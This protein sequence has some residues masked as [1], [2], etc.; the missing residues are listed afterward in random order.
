MKYSLKERIAIGKAVYTHEISSADAM[1]R[2]EISHGTIDKYVNLY[3][4][5]QG[6]PPSPKSHKKSRTFKIKSEPDIDACRSISKEELIN[7]LIRA[8]ADVLRSKK[9]YEVKGGMG[10]TRSSFLYAAR[11]P[12]RNGALRRISRQTD[13]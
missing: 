8:K 12:N 4:E 2:F 6:I 7:E 5:S 10:Q 11:I 3:R 1:Q 13:L 9:G